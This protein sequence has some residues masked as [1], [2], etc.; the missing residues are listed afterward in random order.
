MSEEAKKATVIMPGSTPEEILVTVAKDGIELSDEELEQVTGGASWLDPDPEVICGY[1][2]K[3]FPIKNGQLSV[4]CPN[5]H[6]II[7][8]NWD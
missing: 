3:Q 6:R 4:E 2:R 7:Y 1:C 5:C 8:P